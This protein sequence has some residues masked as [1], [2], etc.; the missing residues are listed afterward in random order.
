MNDTMPPRA[1]LDHAA[2]PEADERP[3][4]K[5]IKDERNRTE[6]LVWLS[7]FG[8]LTSKLVSGLVWPTAARGQTM[9]RRTLGALAD[10]KL[11]VARTM[12]NGTTVYV[13]STRGARY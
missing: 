6:A 10:D 11:D 13:L 5:H 12:A 9:A 2:G 8:W 1:V 7:R 3:E 4:D